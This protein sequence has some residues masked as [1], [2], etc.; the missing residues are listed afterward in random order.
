MFIFYIV[1]LYCT[2][3]YCI[4]KPGHTFK[5]NIKTF[6]NLIESI[7]ADPSVPQKYTAYQL[8]DLK[9]SSPLRSSKCSA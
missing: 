6:Y 4:V 1:T 7:F 2:V 8:H 5:K 3:L 9:N